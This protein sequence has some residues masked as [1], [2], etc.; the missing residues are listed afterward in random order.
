LK[1]VSKVATWRNYT[2]GETVFV[3]GERER[4]FFVVVEGSVTVAINGTRIRDLDNGECFGEMEYLADTGRS[5]GVTVS[6]DSTIIKVERDFKEWASLV[7]QVR[8][9][10]AFQEVLIERLQATSKALARA[11]R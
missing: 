7:T 4:A 2:A 3:E 1:E 6:R 8:L 5:A 10:R 9:N 11:L